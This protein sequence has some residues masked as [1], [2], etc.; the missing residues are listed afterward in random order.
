MSDALL[1]SST[2]PAH[3]PVPPALLWALQFLLLAG[4][5]VT[6][7]FDPWFL[8]GQGTY[9]L[10]VTSILITFI[11]LSTLFYDARYFGKPR[12]GNLVLQLVMFLPFTLFVSRL[13]GRVPAEFEQKQTLLK[14]VME[15]A[16]DGFSSMVGVDVIPRF[17]QEI[18]ATPSIA[19]TLLLLFTGTSLPRKRWIKV[20]WILCAFL[21]PMMNMVTGAHPPTLHWW[22]GA[23]MLF[24]A[25]F[26]MKHDVDEY[27]GDHHLV[28]RLRHVDDANEYRASVRICKEALQRKG[29]SPDSV[30]HIVRRVYGP[31]CPM[32]QEEIAHAICM[33]LVNEHHLLQFVSG[34]EKRFVPTEDFLSKTTDFGRIILFPRDVVI[35]IA[36]ILWWISPLDLIPDM[37]PVVGAIDDMILLWLGT[38]PLFRTLKNVPHRQRMADD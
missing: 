6:M 35:F 17:V 32:R 16:K 26:M 20:G 25:L 8:R 29:L 14:R 9:P 11:T 12:G 1:I 4:A 36:A 27:A 37:L 3:K 33:R 18:F 24:L 34:E 13:F 5:M 22:G 31:E 28:K 38:S 23:V 10:A 30:L 2:P 15:V 21:F 7:W 19:W